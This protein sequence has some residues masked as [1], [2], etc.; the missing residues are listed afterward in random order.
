MCGGRLRACA[1]SLRGVAGAH[2]GA[3]L[4]RRQ[5]FLGQRRGNALQRRLQVEVDVVG[6]RLQRRDVQHP[7]LVRQL[8]AVGQALAQQ[9]VDG[10]EEG[11]ERLARAGGRGDQ[12]MA[13]IED[14]RPGLRLRRR[15]RTE[16]A[17]GT[18]GRWWGG[19][20]SVPG[21][22][23]RPRGARGTRVARRPEETGGE[24]WKWGRIERRQRRCGEPVQSSVGPRLRS[25]GLKPLRQSGT[26]RR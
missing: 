22:C 9:A 14:L 12:G 8:A 24:P 18:S 13:A 19:S 3:D 26:V 1:R 17:A 10:G 20:G 7:G 15:G 11:G 6:Q 25:S 5:A 2:G 4:D 21:A 16:A 23:A